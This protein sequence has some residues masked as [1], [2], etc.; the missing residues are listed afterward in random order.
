MKLHGIKSENISQFLYLQT[1]YKTLRDEYKY[2][3]Q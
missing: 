2:H 1:E 3:G